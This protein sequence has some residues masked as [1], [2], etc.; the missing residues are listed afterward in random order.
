MLRRLCVAFRH[1]NL[2]HLS[3]VI[4]AN[5]R[6]VDCPAAAIGDIPCAA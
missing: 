5:D 2:V 4:P 6:R 3:A 1:R